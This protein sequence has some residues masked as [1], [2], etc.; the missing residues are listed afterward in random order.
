MEE[1]K[2]ALKELME[3]IKAYSKTKHCRNLSDEEWGPEDYEPVF[4]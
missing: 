2:Q 1:E 4:D 3:A